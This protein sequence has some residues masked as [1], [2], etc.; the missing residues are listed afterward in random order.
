MTAADR[1][2]LGLTPYQRAVSD[3]CEL[4]AERRAGILDSQCSGVWFDGVQ[5]WAPERAC[6]YCRRYGH[7]EDACPTTIDATW[8]EET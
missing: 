2:P 6:G 1:D 5:V 7:T 4:Y 8:S 3:A